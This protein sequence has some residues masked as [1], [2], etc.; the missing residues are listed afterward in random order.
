MMYTFIFILSAVLSGY[1]TRATVKPV[2]VR[3]RIRETQFDIINRIINGDPSKYIDNGTIY[4]V[5]RLLNYYSQPAITRL[6]RAFDLPLQ[7][8][9]GIDY[10]NV[11]SKYIKIT[12]YK[13]A[14][15]F[16]L[17]HIIA[18]PEFTNNFLN[19]RLHKYI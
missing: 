11:L 3:I 17:D 12:E 8:I 13:K 4:S 2:E 10:P 9:C 7:K 5:Q 16:K 1:I 15:L 18:T 14:E 6:D 19:A